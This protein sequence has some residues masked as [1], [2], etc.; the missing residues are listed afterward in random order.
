[1]LAENHQRTAGMLA[2]NGRPAGVI[3]TDRRN[4]IHQ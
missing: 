2:A 1:M 4:F 3:V